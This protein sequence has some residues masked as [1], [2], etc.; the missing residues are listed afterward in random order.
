MLTLATGEGIRVLTLAPGEEIRVLT[1]ATGEG[2]NPR[3]IS[4][5]GAAWQA[6]R[7]H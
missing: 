1:L 7:E 5:R 6:G 2:T 3:A 4:G